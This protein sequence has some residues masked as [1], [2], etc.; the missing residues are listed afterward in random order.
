MAD[1]GSGRI[2]KVS[3]SL[4]IAGQVGAED[5]SHGS[6]GRQSQLRRLRRGKA[7]DKAEART[8]VSEF[9]SRAELELVGAILRRRTPEG[10]GVT[11]VP[12]IRGEMLVVASI[13]Y[14]AGQSVVD[15]KIETAYAAERI[16]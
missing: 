10:D 11:E 3:D 4:A 15:L 14:E 13:A 5:F 12:R 6:L 2:Q 9:E 7:A 1:A 16:P 8:V